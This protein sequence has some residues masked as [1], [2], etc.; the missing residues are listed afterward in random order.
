MNFALIRNWVTA[1]ALLLLA[2][3][4][5]PSRV[6]NEDQLKSPV[7][8]IPDLQ[9]LLKK[10]ESADRANRPRAVRMSDGRIAYHYKKDGNAR[11]PT[12][13]ELED[14]IR[15]PKDHSEKQRDIGG[16]LSQL[17]RL[18]V[19][20]KISTPEGYGSSG[21]WSPSE[22]LLTINPAVI[23]GGT[24]EFHETL[25][26][27]AIHVAQSCNGGGIDA[28]PIR[29]GLPVKYWF[30]IDDSLRHPLYGK[31]DEES[32]LIEREAYSHSKETG[33][34]LELL[35]SYCYLPDEE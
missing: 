7:Q 12:I 21:T 22:K 30:T 23:T 35:R 19:L 24:P 3:C 16:L 4:A 15:N 11:K 25:S 6:N 28:L 18:G 10:L 26:H 27:E 17:N 1:T 33:S 31:N 34:A 13:Q 29:L 5:T 32:Q 14:E 9:G 20:V 2:S 8:Q